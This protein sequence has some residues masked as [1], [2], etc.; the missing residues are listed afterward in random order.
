MEDDFDD[1]GYE[2]DP[3][4]NRK[5][6]NKSKRR[7]KQKKRKK[8][9][10]KRKRNHGSTTTPYIL[11]LYLQ[12]VHINQKC[13]CGGKLVK[14]DE[15]PSW[16]YG[17]CLLCYKATEGFHYG[18]RRRGCI[19]I[20]LTN[21]GY[22]VCANCYVETS[23]EGKEETEEKE[24]EVRDTYSAEHLFIAKKVK[25]TIQTISYEVDAVYD[26]LLM[27][28]SS[29]PDYESLSNRNRPRCIFEKVSIR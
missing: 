11:D 9:K 1:M 19:F 4:A 18:C 25:I 21:F 14:Y 15:D 3:M 17:R 24:I 13:Y 27:V 10:K 6:L 22:A 16:C 26:I 2:T 8:K 5:K 12:I 7:S 23:V 28:T 29:R 20:N